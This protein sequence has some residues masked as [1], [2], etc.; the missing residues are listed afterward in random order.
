VQVALAERS[1]HRGPT[2]V[3][4]YIAAIAELGGATLLHDDRSFDTI[5]RLTGQPTEWLAPCGSLD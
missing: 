2:A 5:A 3:D 1:E 4:L